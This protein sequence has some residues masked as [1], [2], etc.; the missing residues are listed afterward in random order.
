M[1]RISLLTAALAMSAA[2]A[3]AQ[4]DGYLLF[5]YCQDYDYGLGQAGTIQAAIEIPAETAEKFAGAK[6]TGMRIG[7]GAA[8]KNDVT[9]FLSQNLR[10][11]P[12]YTQEV[13]LEKQNG[14]NTVIFDTP[15]EITDR[16]FYAG[17]WYAG[18]KQGEY[19]IGVDGELTSITLGDYIAVG[20]NW[21]HVGA[22]FGNMCIQIMIE[23]DNL[24]ENAVAVTDLSLPFIV[25][26]EEE[27]TASARII[28]QGTKAVR[29]I[30]P[31]VYIDGEP[32]EEIQV[33]ITPP[34]LSPGS[35]GLLTVKG[36]SA[37]SES[38]NL[39]LK[40]SVTSVNGTPDDS[41]EDNTAIGHLAVTKQTYSR[42][43][44][45]EEWT[46]AWCGFCVRG[47]VGMN[48]MR[49]TYGNDGFIG[50]AV[51]GQDR[52]QVS[53]YLPFLEKW[54]T[55]GYPGAIINRSIVTDP[56]QQDLESYY[57]VLASSPT[58]ARIETLT[59]QYSSEAQGNLEVNA[60]VSF[61]APMENGDYRLAFVI[62]EDHVGPYPQTNY[63][64]GGAYGVMGGW[65]KRSDPFY[66]FF[67]EVAR[68][69]TDCFGIEGSI[70][71]SLESGTEAS[72]SVSLPLTNISD[73][74]ACTLVALIIDGDSGEIINA[75]KMSLY[76]T[77]VEEIE[78]GL[79]SIL[80]MPGAIE[81]RG[82]YDNC[83]VFTV[84]GKLASSSSSTRIELPA[85]VYVAKV[86]CADG[87]T[88]V[89]K[90]VVK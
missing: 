37:Y 85:G 36:L 20:N 45:V 72:Y 19:P 68:D 58:Y 30:T 17:Y 66:W 10:G 63:Y 7:F 22:M 44:V 5:G 51:H 70:P 69:I 40:V 47:I 81:I 38:S 84:D 28:N 9:L 43:M 75:E 48:Y 18:C 25:K 56:N 11:N 57:R 29:E 65:E 77:G 15:Y 6:V 78:D 87:R 14:W 26:P 4:E 88:V 41:P 42:N 12:S 55:I 74:S 39:E 16:T 59:A 62:T 86:T 82:A 13:T 53:S 24:P 31:Q 2:A 34:T 1:N 71:S 50:I 32:V 73:L 3:F 76:E 83:E 23:G 67:D 27:F 80:S 61:A 64:S 35:S 89:K 21:E 49:E 52:M 90:V 79:V 54:A 46:G 60:G 8:T 33:E